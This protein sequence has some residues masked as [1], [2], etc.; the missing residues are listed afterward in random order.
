MVMYSPAH[1]AA[2]RCVAAHLSLCFR[3]QYSRNRRGLMGTGARNARARALL[4][5][6]IQSSLVTQV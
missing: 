1:Y 4:K 6:I 5:S 2:V 3:I